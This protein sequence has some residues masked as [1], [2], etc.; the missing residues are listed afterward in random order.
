MKTLLRSFGLM[1]LLVAAPLCAEDEQKPI[2][3]YACAPNSARTLIDA[4]DDG[5]LD[6]VSCL[7][8]NGADVNVQDDNGMTALIN[9][10]EAYTLSRVFGDADDECS[11]YQKIV[12]VL[13][14]HKG[15]DIN[16]IFFVDNTDGDEHKESTVLQIAADY[17]DLMIVRRLLQV[18]HIKKNVQN[19]EGQSAL[20]FAAINGYLDVVTE[21]LVH[22]VRADLVDNHK[23]TAQDYA[24]ENGHDAVASVLALNK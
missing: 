18:P 5:N 3:A 20:H 1:L 8:D 13:C 24:I 9:A 23:K 22:G 10:I 21:L 12:S 14:A 19:Y 17:G 15:L 16:A 6:E 4:V 11:I 2:D 7:L